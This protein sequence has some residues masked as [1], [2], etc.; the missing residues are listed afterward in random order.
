MSGSYAGKCDRAKATMNRK[1]QKLENNFPKQEGQRQLT[2]ET[3]HLKYIKRIRSE[4]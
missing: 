2:L 1:Y 4:A 3:I